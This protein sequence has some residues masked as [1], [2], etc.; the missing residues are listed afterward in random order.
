VNVRGLVDS[1]PNRLGAWQFQYIGK[2]NLDAKNQN[3][4]IYGRVICGGKRTTLRTRMVHT[5]VGAKGIQTALKAKKY[6][7]VHLPEY[8]RSGKNNIH[9]SEKI[10]SH[11]KRWIKKSYGLADS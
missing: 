1:Y 11:M 2:M 4:E 9:Q 5:F 10:Q 3:K 7:T 8:T 6:G